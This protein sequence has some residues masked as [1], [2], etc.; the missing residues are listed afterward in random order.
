MLIVPSG[1]RAWL[2][3][4][5]CCAPVSY[6]SISKECFIHLS[7]RHLDSEQMTSRHFPS[8]GA[9][10]GRASPSVQH[11]DVTMIAYNA[12]TGALKSDDAT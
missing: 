1:Q 5:A 2:T 6:L 9:D 4:R 12:N 11:V 3:V 7:V 10:S 8:Y